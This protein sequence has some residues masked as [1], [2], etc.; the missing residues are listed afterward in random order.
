MKINDFE[1]GTLNINGKEIKIE[2]IEWNAN[3]TCEGVF[4]KH[5]IKGENTNNQISCHIVKISPHC[6]IKLHNHSGKT[7]LHEVMDGSGEC[8]IE[9]TPIAYK[10]GVI[11]LILADKNHLVKAGN[12]NLYLF[13]KFFPALL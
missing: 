11:T 9:G 3:P 7:E 13:A 8:I 6:E 4:L 2:E 1:K 12:E 5:L 10:K